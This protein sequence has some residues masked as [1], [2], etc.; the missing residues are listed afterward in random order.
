MSRKK[1]K[2]KR[3]GEGGGGTLTF[4]LE[5]KNI[6][7]VLNSNSKHTRVFLDYGTPPNKIT[8]KLRASIVAVGGG[9]G[10][11]VP[12]SLGSGTLVYAYDTNL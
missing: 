8:L 2:K 4:E 9:D 12:K 1:K 7:V 10:W 6:C 5:Y 3:G 11:V